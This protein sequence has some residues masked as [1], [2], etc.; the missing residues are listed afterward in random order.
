MADKQLTDAQI[1]AQII[2]KSQQSHKTESTALFPTEI[3]PLPSKGLVYPKDNPL[4]AG[5]VE[6]RYMTA[7]DEDIL[8]NQNY[9]KQGIALDKLYT[10]LVIGNGEGQSVNL[11][12]MILGDRSAIMLAARV[13]G[14]GSDYTVR[15]PHPETGIEMEVTVDLNLLTPTPI[16]ESLYNN[17]REFDY[18]LPVSG[19]CV[20]VRLQTA[21]EQKAIAKAT[22]I[23]EQGG[24]GTKTATTVL[25]HTV[26]AIDG[27][28]DQKE[29][30]EFVDN[31]L[32]ARDSLH[33]RHFVLDIT[34]DYDLAIDIDIPEHSFFKRMPLPIDVD[35]FWPR[36]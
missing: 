6:I 1:K 29:I 25:K 20:T 11:N 22:K 23:Q 16:D 24:Q 34:P 30:A 13:L 32:L 26:V 12:D 8:T 19:R 14:Y 28:E 3:V 9:L 27:I 35:F 10:A 21:V 17:T 31:Q 15:L 2:A 5:Q 4:S 36:S 7:K 18:V 33:L